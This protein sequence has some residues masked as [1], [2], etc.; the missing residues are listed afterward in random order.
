MCVCVLLCFFF[1]SFTNITSGSWTITGI[2][3][4]HQLLSKKITFASHHFF[5][6]NPRKAHFREDAYHLQVWTPKLKTAYIVSYLLPTYTHT[7]TPLISSLNSIIFYLKQL[8]AWWEEAVVFAFPH[9]QVPWFFM[10]N[11]SKFGFTAVGFKHYIY[12]FQNR[13]TAVEYHLRWP[14]AVDGTLK[15]KNYDSLMDSLMY[16]W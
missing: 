2:R 12:T 3:S 9:N 15:S 16:Y 8:A 1:V 7:H 10:L 4:V 11:W 14:Q 13:V 5:F 6:L